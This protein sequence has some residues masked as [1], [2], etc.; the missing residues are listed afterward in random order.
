M[1]PIPMPQTP[2]NAM[3]Y[4]KRKD[5]P[6]RAYYMLPTTVPTTVPTTPSPSTRLMTHPNPTTLAPA[7]VY[8]PPVSPALPSFLP[9][10]LK[11][12]NINPA[13]SNSPSVFVK[14]PSTYSG[15]SVTQNWKH[16]LSARALE[17]EP[18]A[19]YVAMALMW[20]LQQTSRMDE[21]EPPMGTAQEVRVVGGEG[22]WLGVE[23]DI[24]WLWRFMVE[25]F[26]NKWLIFRKDLLVVSTWSCCWWLELCLGCL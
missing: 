23:Q 15:L 5:S 3:N 4:K 21:F 2:R 22:I 7:L 12:S 20:P 1:I 14:Q 11:H 24:L 25:W 6:S 13:F 9:A 17:E 8:A 16:P 10:T 26:S 18:G 19:E